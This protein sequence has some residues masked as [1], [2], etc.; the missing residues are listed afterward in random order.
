MVELNS[1]IRKKCLTY[2]EKSL[3][4]LTLV[5]LV[6]VVGYVLNLYH[7]SCYVKPYGTPGRAIL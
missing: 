7:K 2:K 4:R 6:T 5:G 1:K 3:V